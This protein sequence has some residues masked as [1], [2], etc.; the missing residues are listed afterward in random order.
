VTW[1]SLARH[2]DWGLRDYGVDG[3]IGLEATPEAFVAK[4]V[5]VFREV[6]RVLA[7]HGTLWLNLGDSYASAPAGNFGSGTAPA[8]GGAFRAPKPKMNYA[9]LKQKDLCGMP[10]RVALALQAD[11]WYLRSDIIWH[12][13]N[14]MPE[15]CR[16]RPTKAHEYLFLLTKRPKYFYDQE[17]I[18]EP[19]ARIWNPETLGGNL[20][21]GVHKRNGAMREQE[22]DT[23]SPNPSGRNKR[24]VWTIP[25]QAMS[26]AHFATFPQKLVEPCILAGTSAKGNCPQC[27]KPWERVVDRDAP[28][29]KSQWPASW[30]NRGFSGEKHK[31]AHTHNSTGSITTGWRPTCSCGITETRPGIVL[32]PFGGSGTVGVVAGRLK[33]DYV[34]I[35]L[36]AEY[37]DNIARPRLAHIETAVPVAE[38]KAGQMPL[39]TTKP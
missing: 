24:S 21:G 10:W 14:P 4:M 28:K 27:G 11:G 2:I 18:R 39:F 5:E 29:D 1:L 6:K 25:T 23:P 8:D 30:G 16:D 15:S 3:Q 9:G 38:A 13:P 26:E 31:G 36:S 19:H 12:K 34:L 37:A 33:R 17:A 35:E 20:S 22:R 7:D 32:D